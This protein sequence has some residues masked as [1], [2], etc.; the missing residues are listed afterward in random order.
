LTIIVSFGALCF[1]YSANAVAIEAKK[2]M[3]K[4]TE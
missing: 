3:K 1:S 2:I 4:I